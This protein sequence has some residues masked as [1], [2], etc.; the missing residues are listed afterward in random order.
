M[1]KRLKVFQVFNK[2]IYIVMSIKEIRQSVRMQFRTQVSYANI[3]AHTA[4]TQ[5]KKCCR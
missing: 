2:K 3:K 4:K 1:S 5:P